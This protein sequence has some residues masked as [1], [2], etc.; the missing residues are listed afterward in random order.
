MTTGI[1]RLHSQPELSRPDHWRA[2]L[3]ARLPL[4]VGV[5]LALLNLVPL[6]ARM[7]AEEALLRSQFG[8]E[9]EAYYAKT[10]RLIPWIY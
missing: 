4:F 5:I 7:D 8:A 9:Y 1:Y 10:W 6:I 3:G 2:R